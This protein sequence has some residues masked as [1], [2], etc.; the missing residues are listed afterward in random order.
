VIAI[1]FIPMFFWGFET[2]S[3]RSAAK[4]KQPAQP[5]GGEPGGAVDVPH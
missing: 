5:A 4:K 3:E 1:F 2:L